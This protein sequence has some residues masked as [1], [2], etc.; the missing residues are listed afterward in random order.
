MQAQSDLTPRNSKHKT[1][2]DKGSRKSALVRTPLSASGS[3]RPQIAPRAQVWG[4]YHP[5][6][7]D[8]IWVNV[9]FQD[10]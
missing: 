1:K 9:R 3:Y 6:R 5:S 7:H 4:P 2:I 8:T 10:R